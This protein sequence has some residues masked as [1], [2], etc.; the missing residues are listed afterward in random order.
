MD[1]TRSPLGM[2]RWYLIVRVIVTSPCSPHVV[3]RYVT[4][5]RRS[6]NG[7]GVRGRGIKAYSVEGHEEA[8]ATIFDAEWSLDR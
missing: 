7:V 6:A 4:A 2:H 3:T 1:V 8:I 5:T